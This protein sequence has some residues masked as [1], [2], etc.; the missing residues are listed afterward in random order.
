[1]SKQYAAIKW[2]F[3]GL[4]VLSLMLIASYLSLSSAAHAQAPSAG[5]ENFHDP[6]YGFSLSYP[7]TWMLVPERNG[8]H[9]TLLHPATQ[10]T[11]SP[12]VT[13]QTGTPADV[14]K[15]ARGTEGKI[16]LVMGQAAVDD[17][18][19]YVPASAMSSP[20]AISEGPHQ[21]RTIILPVSNSGRSTNVYTFMLTQPTDS[22]G[23]VSTAVQADNVT[24]DAI[25]N[26]FTLPTQV[27]SVT[28]LA[29]YSCDAVCWADNNWN[30]TYYDDSAGPYSIYCD[31]VGYDVNSSYT[32]NPHCDDG[33]FQAAQ[34]PG[35]GYYQ[36]NFQCADFVARALTQN[37]LI[38]GVGNGGVNGQS[39]VTKSVGTYSF[40]NYRFTYTPYSHNTVYNLILVSSLKQYLL[41][42]G[43]GIDIG[44]DL[45]QAQPGDVVIYYTVDS[46]GQELTDTHAA[47]ITSTFQ[48]GWSDGGGWDALIDGHNLSSYHD[49]LQ[50]RAAANPQLK[51][52]IIHMRGSL[53]GSDAQSTRSGSGWTKF[54]DGYGRTS[55]WV[56]TT[57][58]KSPTAWT[59]FSDSSEATTC[60]VV[61]YVPSGHGTATLSFGVQMNNG[62]W[63]YRTVNESN[64]DSWALLFKW[65]ELS[66]P[67]SIIK[68]S[69]N[70]GS[71]TQQMGIGEM[72]FLC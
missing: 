28:P 37:Y 72:A 9:I 5:W 68:V 17:L 65:G 20:D 54:T 18:S 46:Q 22:T 43:L 14:L 6:V 56:K 12:I 24:F 8:S 62:S 70:N 11:M 26:S 61:V 27:T 30:F 38:A 55:Y 23:K 3:L 57:N 42:S 16:R 25:L 40:Q 69:N 66:A 36:P 10:T 50:A 31:S 58:K 67:P 41:D 1:M 39:P 48:D 33:N 13:T 59:Q 49:T 63:V 51:W 15:H 60:A 34:V 52:K 44:T 29:H 53:G 2:H 47:L 35:N 19:P 71:T 21:T 32:T 4:T 64:I 45:A 7:D